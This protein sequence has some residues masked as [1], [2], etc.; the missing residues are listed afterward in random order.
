MLNS[1]DAVAYKS[2]E[3]GLDWVHS[4]IICFETYPRHPL[5]TDPLLPRGRIH[6]NCFYFQAITGKGAPAIHSTNHHEIVAK[7]GTGER[8]TDP[9]LSV[10]SILKQ[11]TDPDLITAALEIACDILDEN[12]CILISC[13]DHQSAGVVFAITFTC[14][15][16]VHY[17]IQL[18]PC[19]HSPTWQLPLGPLFL[20]IHPHQRVS[21]VIEFKL[22]DILLQ[23]SVY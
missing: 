3:S 1:L 12:Q 10:A 9:L 13:S 11:L 15:N 18:L 6:P 7:E 16:R 14:Y 21:S 20:Q 23:Y 5:L 17:Y 22:P 8:V 2:Q 4:L 19:A